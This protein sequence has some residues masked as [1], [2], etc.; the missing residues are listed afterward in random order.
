MFFY[1]WVVKHI[2]DFAALVGALLVLAPIWKWIVKT[3]KKMKQI[4]SL[5]EQLSTLDTKLNAIYSQL[6]TNGGSSLRDS[7][8]RIEKRAVFT[9]EFVKTIYKESEKAMFQTNAS[10]DCIW[11]NKTLLHLVDMESSEV[12]G[13][14]WVN[15]ISMED[16]E[17]VMNEWNN[18]IANSRDFDM[19]YTTTKGDKVHHVARAIRSSDLKAIGYLGTISPISTQ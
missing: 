7:I 10:G 9:E 11:V 3:F 8:D 16:K 2:I 4:W 13:Q 5:N 18:A 1:A 17:D 12:M 6:V 14:G 15:F 19:E